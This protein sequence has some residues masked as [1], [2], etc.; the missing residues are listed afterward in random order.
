ML[1]RTELIDSRFFMV[2]LAVMVALGPMS[3]DAYLPAMANIADYFNTDITVV[4][5]T[6][7]SFLIGNGIGQFFGGA[8][9]DQ[10]GRKTI[11]LIGLIIFLIS[12]L[13]IIQAD[14]VAAIQVFRL[15][16]ALGS[17][18]TSVIC[19]AQVRDLYPKEEVMRRYANVMLIMLVAPLL[20]PMIGAVLVQ[21]GWQSIF[22]FLGF[23]GLAVLIVYL[24][25]IPETIQ[26]KATTFSVKELFSGYLHVIKY[27]SNGRYLASQFI[28]FGGVSSGIFMSFLTN[29]ALIYMEY[30]SV[31]EFQFALIFGAHALML[32]VGNRLAV[33]LADYF[34]G[35]KV[36][37]MINLLQLSLTTLLLL[38][39]V[40][41]LHT[42]WSVLL[43]T[44]LIM[45]VNGAINPTS[46]GLFIVH[47]DKNAGAASSL[48]TTFIFVVGAIVGGLSAVLSDGELLPIF[49][50]M[51]ICSM[52]ARAILLGIK[53]E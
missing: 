41:N 8:L 12:T 40:L 7:S 47:F 29:S 5:L 48:K 13:F 24:F 11:G 31:S 20:A 50:I 1:T 27:Q 35:L 22:A 3:V 4:N 44:L 15:T 16:Q 25:L 14:S 53:P 52:I 45:S 23:W 49:A 46:S 32:M 38:L 21:Y 9:S 10:M 42:L 6:M 2:F 43:F 33:K 26:E 34:P 51:M 17:G 39:T 36:L 18:F 30:F 19:L 37:R 28:L